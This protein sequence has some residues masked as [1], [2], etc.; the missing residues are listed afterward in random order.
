MRGATGE[1]E[2]GVWSVPRPGIS[3]FLTRDWFFVTGILRDSSL[4]LSR[5]P[6]SSSPIPLFS[7]QRQAFFFLLSFLADDG[8]NDD[9]ARQQALPYI[10]PYLKLA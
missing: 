1:G 7:K 2:G 3:V 10:V 4:F 9:L 8:M 5:S 6:P